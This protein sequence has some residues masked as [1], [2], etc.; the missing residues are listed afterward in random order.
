MTRV[1]TWVREQ[2]QAETNDDVAG[3]RKGESDG[4]D[5]A[6][7]LTLLPCMMDKLPLLPDSDGLASKLIKPAFFYLA[8]A[9]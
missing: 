9:L 2:P 7:L 8:C 4:D 3:T 1:S 6:L 5:W